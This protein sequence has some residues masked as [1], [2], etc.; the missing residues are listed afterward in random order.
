MAY[1]EPFHYTAWFG[2]GLYFIVT[3]PFLYL[4]TR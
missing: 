3:P 2:I 1:V 4:S